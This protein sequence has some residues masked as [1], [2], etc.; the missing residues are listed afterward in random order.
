MALIEQLSRQ[1]DLSPAFIDE[2]YSRVVTIQLAKQD[3]FIQQGKVANFIGLVTEGSLFSSTHTQDGQ[4]S[5]DD[6]FLPGSFVASYRSF[7]TRCPS[8]GSIQ[9]YSSTTLYAISYP[10]YSAIDQSLDWVKFFKYISEV[11]FIRK[12]LKTTS[13]TT[14]TAAQRYAKLVATYPLIEQQFPQYLIAS[15]LNVR[16]ETLS[17]LKS[18][19]LHQGKAHP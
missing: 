9:A 17:R 7:L 4:Q 2:F 11:L 6:F 13:L 12:C 18:L 16:P 8:P 5:V 14:E 15:F 10:T 3:Y 19:D 1:L